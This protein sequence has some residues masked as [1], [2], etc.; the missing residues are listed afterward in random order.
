LNSGSLF[1][2]SNYFPDGDQ[3]KLDYQTPAKLMAVHMMA[4]I[5]A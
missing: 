4:A 3:K 5:A 1:P 2:C